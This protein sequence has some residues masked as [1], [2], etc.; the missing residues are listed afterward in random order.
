MMRTYHY[1]DNLRLQLWFD[2]PNHCAAFLV[3]S[4]MVSIGILLFFVS[5]DEKPHKVFIAAMFCAIFG[6]EALLALTYSRG[7]Y[8]ALLAALPLMWL[9]CR[10]KRLLVFNLVFLAILFIMANGVDRVQSVMATG[11]GSIKHR[12]LL[13]QGGLS[14]IWNNPG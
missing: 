10:R 14:I 6:Q 11:D 5:R 13:W 2:S 1:L 9:F 3:M 4:I 7:G 12:L 8:I